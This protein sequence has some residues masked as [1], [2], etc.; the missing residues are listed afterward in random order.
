MANDVT[1]LSALPLA[2]GRQDFA[3]S[4]GSSQPLAAAPSQQVANG[5]SRKEDP[6]ADLQA[7]RDRIQQYFQK[8]I[9]QQ[10]QE[11]QIRVDRATGLTIVQIYNRGSGELVRQIPSE[12]VVRI[13]QFL[14]QSPL[15][16]DTKA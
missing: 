2:K 8:V 13:A 4:T 12:E 1:T 9:A 5:R 10:D 6:Q 14:K 16:V 7:A 3:V 15:L 11:A